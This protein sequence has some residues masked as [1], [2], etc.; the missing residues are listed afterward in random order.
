MATRAGRLHLII[1]PMF[2]GKTTHMM[3]Y[4]A[5]KIR[6]HR[7]CVVISH[8]TDKR[9]DEHI[10]CT[11][12]KQTFDVPSIKCS[13]LTE[14]ERAF[15]DNEI[16]GIDEIQFFGLSAE[17]ATRVVALLEGWLLRGKIIICAGLDSD[18]RGIPFSILAPL[19][20]QADKVKKL[21]AACEKCG[22]RAGFSVRKI[23]D[24]RVYANPVGGGDKYSAYCRVCRKQDECRV[25]RI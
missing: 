9:Y 4:L 18:Y 22:A 15:S 8:S 5:Q 10:I 25:E 1:G 24:D 6:E 16:I 21:H 14:A 7:R 17:S 23:A 20:V 13:D 12:A 19:I 11:H 2:S 3:T